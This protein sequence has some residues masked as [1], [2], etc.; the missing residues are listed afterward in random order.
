[1]NFKKIAKLK[2]KTTLPPSFLDGS[3]RETNSYFY[4]AQD[5]ISIL[6][7]CNRQCY[8]NQENFSCDN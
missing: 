4:L 2:G 5:F 1:M 7:I 6:N 3:A 8:A